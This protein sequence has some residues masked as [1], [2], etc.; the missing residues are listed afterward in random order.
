MHSLQVFLLYAILKNQ[1]SRPL[2]EPETVPPEAVETQQA[3]LITSPRDAAI[4]EKVVTK[5][6]RNNKRAARRSPKAERKKARHT[7]S[8][9]STCGACHACGRC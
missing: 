4:Y 2:D 3:E 5:S 1:R 7:R 6:S 8:S 9:V